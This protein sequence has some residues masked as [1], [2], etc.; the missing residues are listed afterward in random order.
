MQPNV[1]ETEMK[2]TFALLSLA[3]VLGVTALAQSSALSKTAGAKAGCCDNCGQ[4]C[5]PDCCPG[6]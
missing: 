3:V 4:G 5:S 1:K 6:K 2:R